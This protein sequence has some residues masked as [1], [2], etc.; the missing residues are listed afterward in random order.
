M[1]KPAMAP[2][3]D[4]HYVLEKKVKLTRDKRWSDTEEKSCLEFFFSLINLQFTLTADLLSL[5]INSKT[6]FSIYADVSF[7]HGLEERIVSQLSQAQSQMCTSAVIN[8]V[9]AQLNLCYSY[10]IWTSGD[11]PN[12]ITVKYFKLLL[13]IGSLKIP[14]TPLTS[15][16]PYSFPKDNSRTDKSWTEKCCESQLVMC[17]TNL[18]QR[19]SVA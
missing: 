4:Q 16:P 10:L 7:L 11:L 9:I 19:A 2:E 17:A 1:E 6:S 12:S 3:S 13:H 15:S 14:P 5:R 8:L 18:V